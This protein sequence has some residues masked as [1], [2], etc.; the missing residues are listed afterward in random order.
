MNVFVLTTGR[1][2]S[3]A[4]INACKFISNYT[5][6]HESNSRILT[7]EKFKYSTNH[8]EADNRLIWFL[9]SLDK[10]FGNEA[11]YVNL[12]RNK[13]ETVNSLKKRILSN[14]SIIRS[15][16]SG[17]LKTPYQT[18]D[19]TEIDQVTNL[20]YDTVYDNI[21]LF[22]KDKDNC[23]T[24]H[25][26]SINEDFKK[27]WDEINAEGDLQA[28]LNSFDSPVNATKKQLNLGYKL[29]SF[30]QQQLFHLKKLK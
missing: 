17:I 14:T 11:L 4:F 10:A 16:A 18:L 26:E 5:S 28:A 24:V 22:L 3:A 25:L 27:F 6:G 7:A 15:F 2:G 8:I 21:A 13:K 1:S 29:K 9:G 19:D 30:V 12:V 20:Y 23:I